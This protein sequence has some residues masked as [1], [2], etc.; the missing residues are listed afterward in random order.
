GT[1]MPP[2]TTVVII[3]VC[4][5]LGNCRSCDVTLQAVFGPGCT[6]CPCSTN[7]LIVNGSFENPPFGIGGDCQQLPVGPSIMPGWTVT[8]DE[9]AR[10]QFA[11]PYNVMPSDGLLFADLT[12]YSDAP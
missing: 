5:A 7:N 1:Q 12:G 10:C 11:A 4:D 8:I 2:G 9:I 6:P 3:N